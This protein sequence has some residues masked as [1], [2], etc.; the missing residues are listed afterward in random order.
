MLVPP[1]VTDSLQPH[2]RRSGVLGL[3]IPP[4]AISVLRPD[5]DVEPAVFERGDPARPVRVRER[6]AGDLGRAIPLYEAALADCERALG[7]NHLVTKDLRAYLSV[8]SG[9]GWSAWS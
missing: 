1:D 4:S 5:D 9:G 7:S 8:E 3:R 6:L 2:E